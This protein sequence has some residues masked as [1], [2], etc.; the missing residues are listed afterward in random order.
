M[1]PSAHVTPAGRPVTALVY[2]PGTSL[3]SVGNGES[4]LPCT[5]E[6]GSMAN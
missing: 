2:G 1:L 5:M 6:F 4:K 3:P